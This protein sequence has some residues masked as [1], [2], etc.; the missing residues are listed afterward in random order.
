MELSHECMVFI[1]DMWRGQNEGMQYYHEILEKYAKLVWENAATYEDILTKNVEFIRG[2]IVI[3]PNYYGPF[4]PDCEKVSDDIISL[5]K[6]GILVTDGQSCLEK[7]D[8][9]LYVHQRAYLEIIVPKTEEYLRMII[10]LFSRSDE[11]AVIFNDDDFGLNVNYDDKIF[12]IT[13]QRWFNG[14]EPKCAHMPVYEHLNNDHCILTYFPN[15]V[16]ANDYLTVSIA[17]HD[18]N[19]TGLE[20]EILSMCDKYAIAEV[21]EITD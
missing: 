20:R 10:E 12:W 15:V 2:N 17:F 1:R 3:T 16:D 19:Q 21:I 6:R 18:W 9:R 7:R 4:I 5:H 14:F 13:V 11:F 8:D